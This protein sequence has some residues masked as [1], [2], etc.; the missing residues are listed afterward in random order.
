MKLRRRVMSRMA[1]GGRKP[2]LAKG[3]ITKAFFEALPPDELSLWLQPDASL[4]PV[5]RAKNLDA[6]E[7]GPSDSRAPGLE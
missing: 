3:R 5:H 2:G 4:D 6:A 7:G 1:N